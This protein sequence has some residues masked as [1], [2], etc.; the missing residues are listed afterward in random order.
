[1]RNLQEHYEIRKVP[2]TETYTAYR[3]Y[4]YTR[5]AY[6]PLPWPEVGVTLTVTS[7]NG[8]SEG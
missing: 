1:V 6:S 8:Y 4:K 7:R 3:V 5:T 2:R